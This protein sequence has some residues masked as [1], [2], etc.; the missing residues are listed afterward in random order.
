MNVCTNHFRFCPLTS[1]VTNNFNGCLCQQI[2]WQ[3][4][5]KRCWKQRS[6]SSQIS[7]LLDWY[8]IQNGFNDNLEM[9]PAADRLFILPMHETDFFLTLAWLALN[10]GNS[11]LN[12]RSWSF[13]IKFPNLW[14]TSHKISR[15][16]HLISVFMSYRKR[17]G[18]GIKNTK[19]LSQNQSQDV[20]N[21]EK[22]IHI[23]SSSN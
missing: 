13:D 21:S 15:H 11:A 3:A 14:R 16:S 9:K 12:S 18:K 2:I 23:M 20:I 22:N 1:Q 7:L 6:C 19:Q 17:G 10:W 8:I 4:W 5:C